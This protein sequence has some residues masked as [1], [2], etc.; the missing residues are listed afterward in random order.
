[1]FSI[2]IRAIL[3][4][5]SIDFLKLIFTLSNFFLSLLNGHN[6]H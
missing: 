4:R 3:S 1:M 2:A 5:F 6:L